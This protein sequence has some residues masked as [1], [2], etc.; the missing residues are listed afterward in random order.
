MWIAEHVF[1]IKSRGVSMF[2]FTTGNSP[3]CFDTGLSEGLVKRG[4]GALGITPERVRHVF[5]T[6]TDRDHL[7]G[8]NLFTNADV[9]LSVD[10]EQMINRTT[11]RFLGLV[12]NPILK[13]PYKLLSNGDLVQAGQT[14]VQAVATPG[15]TPGS[16]SYLVNDSVLFVG[17]TLVLH[18]GKARPFSRRHVRDLTH[19]DIATQTESAKKLAKLENISLMAT[20]HTGFT[21]EFESAMTDWV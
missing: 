15:H 16:M 3:I 18:Q 8:L 6:H 13:R 10:E 17:D 19:M 21:T 12:Y 4:F 7:G 1:E 14:R 5:L 20:G 11:P 2:V 9:Y